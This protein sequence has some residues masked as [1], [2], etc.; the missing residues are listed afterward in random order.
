MHAPEPRVDRYVSPDGKLTFLVIREEGDITLGFDGYPS[1][2]HGD[3]LAELS[4]LPIEVA[5]EQYVDALLN[6]RSIIG[7]YSWEGGVQDVGIV[8]DPLLPDWAKPDVK[9]PRSEGETV[10][11]RL[12]DGTKVA[13]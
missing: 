1:H 2:T 6:G 9:S 8:D 3:I 7:L 12:W 5:V 4:G 13:I 10:E 11:F